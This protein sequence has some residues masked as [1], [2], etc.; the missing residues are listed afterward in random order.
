MNKQAVDALELIKKNIVSLATKSVMDALVKK[1]T[2]MAWGPINSIAS[3]LIGKLLRF[4]ITKTIL[5]LYVLKAHYNVDKQVKEVNEV[6]KE[7]HS[8][9]ELSKERLKEIDEELIKKARKLITISEH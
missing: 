2:F 6:L 1:A 5:E 7:I 4:A 3:M 9:E 8:G